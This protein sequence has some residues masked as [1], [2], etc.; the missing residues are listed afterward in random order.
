MKISTSILNAKNR[1]ESIVKLNRTNTSYIH[2]DVMDGKFVKDTQFNKI[3][4]IS[5]LNIVSTYPLDIHLMVENPIKYIKELSNMNIEYITFHIEVDKDINKIISSIKDL[6]Y[7]VGLAIKP[8][9]DINKLKKYLDAI[10]LILVMSVEPGKGGQP[11]LDT[12]PNRIK[13]IKELI[14][15]KNILIEVDGGINEDTINMIKDIDIAVAGS[16]I[17]NSDNYYRKIEKLLK[18]NKKVKSIET[19]QDLLPRQGTKYILYPALIPIIIL[20]LY[21]I[22][23]AIFGIDF[24][25]PTYG[26][27]AIVVV[28]MGW[29]LEFW[30]AWLIDILLIIFCL[31]KLKSKKTSN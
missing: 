11:F 14:K 24:F 18:Y 31:I 16:Y 1:I 30:P 12:T 9:T 15:D 6:G 17:I 4:E 7:K 10:D 22:H 28:I 21:S 29:G 25:G 26:I 5:S 2:V 3:K 19:K 13:E 20:L 23:S 27:S 8:N